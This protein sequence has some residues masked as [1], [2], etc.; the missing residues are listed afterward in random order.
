MKYIFLLLILS[1]CI[2]GCKT[3]RIEDNKRVGL[4]IETDTIEG[5]AY[6]SRG[7]YKKGAE[8][9]TW[10][11]FTNGRIYKKEVYRDSISKTTFYH[12]NGK[13]M[14]EG[15][16]RLSHEGEYLHWYYEGKWHEYDTLGHLV[17]IKLY[18]KGELINQIN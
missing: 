5:L 3:N 14:L 2:I 8:K 15:K 10:K 9:K 6:T 13:K 18:D 12:K 1:Q 7:R 16:S 17:K 11:Y 4:W